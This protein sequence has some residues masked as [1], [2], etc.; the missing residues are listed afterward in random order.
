MDTKSKIFLNDIYA[1]RQSTRFTSDAKTEGIVNLNITARDIID[2]EDVISGVALNES[3][4]GCCILLKDLRGLEVGHF[5]RVKVG[6]LGPYI[7]QVRW[8]GTVDDNGMYR[9]GVHFQ[10]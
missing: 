7:A 3:Y 6:N 5:C 9:V 8:I 4:T 2:G 10:E 1:R